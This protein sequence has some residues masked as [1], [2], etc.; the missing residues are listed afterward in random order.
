VEPKVWDINAGG[1]EI[2][3]VRFQRVL[4]IVYNTQNYWDFG[5]CPSSVDNTFRKVDLF[6]SSGERGDTYCVVSL[7]GPVIQVSSF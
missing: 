6:P 1:D 5:I 4:T 2:G 3:C 7:P